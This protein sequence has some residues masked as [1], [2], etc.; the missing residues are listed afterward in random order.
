MTGTPTPWYKTRQAVVAAAAAVGLIVG[1][2]V[3]MTAFASDP[4]E[5]TEYAELQQ[6]LKTANLAVERVDAREASLDEKERA[7]TESNNQLLSDKSDLAER[8]KA[9]GI[10]EKKKAAN[11][12]ESDGVYEVGPDMKAGRYKTSGGSSC[13]FAVLR[14]SDSTDISTN[15]L[16]NGQAYVTVN[17]GQYFETRGCG[18]WVRQ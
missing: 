3:G 13:Y 9:V 8:E 5:S 11:T 4:T 14:S 16:P 7:I 18:E 15:G 6:E 2:V 10:A 12:I 17:K 1:T